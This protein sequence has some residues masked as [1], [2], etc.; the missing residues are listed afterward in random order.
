VRSKFGY[1]LLLSK[2]YFRFF[3][4]RA[5][6]ARWFIFKP[7][8]LI[9]GNFG[10]YCN[11]RCWYIVCS[12]GQRPGHLVYFMTIRY[13]SPILVYFS[14][15]W[16]VEPRKIWQPCFGPRF[17]LCAISSASAVCQT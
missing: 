17:Y 5:R 13:I 2:V 15:F 6:V 8:I 11:V 1:T 3:Y 14:P 4:L 10:G 12:F 7:K 9:W 16:I